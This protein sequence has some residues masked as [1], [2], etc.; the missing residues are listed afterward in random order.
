MRNGPYFRA[1]RFFLKKMHLTLAY[2]EP[3]VNQSVMKS[4]NL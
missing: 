1:L 4:Q 2:I 3:A